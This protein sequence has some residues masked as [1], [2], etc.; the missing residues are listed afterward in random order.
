VAETLDWIESLSSDAGFGLVPESAAPF[1]CAGGGDSCLPP[2]IP[3]ATYVAH[4]HELGLPTAYINFSCTCVFT[5]ATPAQQI[6]EEAAMQR[7]LMDVCF[8]IS[9]RPQILA[10]TFNLGTIGWSPGRGC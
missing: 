6:S 10:F 8:G 3:A 4:L 1:V 9:G 5:G 7:L 2:A